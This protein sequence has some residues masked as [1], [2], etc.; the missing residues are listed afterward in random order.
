MRPQPP[1]P[2]MQTIEY[3]RMMEPEQCGGLLQ[4]ETDSSQWIHL[5]SARFGPGRPCS[6]N[7]KTRWNGDS[8]R[9]DV[10][11]HSV[12]DWIGLRWTHG[13][14]T[15]WL[16]EKDYTRR[17]E[18]SLLLHIAQLP[19]EPQRWDYCHLLAKSLDKTAHA[20]RQLEALHWERAIL[21]KRITI[22]RRNKQRR[23]DILSPVELAQRTTK[24]G[25]AG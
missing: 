10:F 9:Y 2:E 20:A 16:V 21:E 18:Q 19:N 4:H 11:R 5:V 13:G 22:R 24:R 3:M 17:G 7:D 25:L 1:I 15:G 6:H 12:H 8:Y 14:G 23:V